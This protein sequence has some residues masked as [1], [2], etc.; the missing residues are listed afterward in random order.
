MARLGPVMLDIERGDPTSTVTVRYSIRFNRLD[1]LGNLRYQET[2]Q[3]FSEDSPPDHDGFL[4]IFPPLIILLSPDGHTTVAYTRTAQVANNILHEDP[5]AGKDEI[6]AKVC[7]RSL[8][9]QFLPICRTSNT[10]MDG[11]ERAALTAL[12]RPHR[13]PPSATASRSASRSRPSRRLKA[14]GRSWET[15]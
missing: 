11:C 4:F 8:D 3:L 12:P 14:Q 7:L 5:S 2:I 13:T 15:Q 9:A 1:I 6:Y 10:V